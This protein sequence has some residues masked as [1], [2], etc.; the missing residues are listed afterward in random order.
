VSH[1]GSIG[2][3][4]LNSTKDSYSFSLA[5]SE[6]SYLSNFVKNA[7]NVAE[8]CGS[9]MMGVV[10]KNANFRVGFAQRL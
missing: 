3:G 1:A 5:S 6:D 10:T 2:K 4:S 7:I 9:R 8:S